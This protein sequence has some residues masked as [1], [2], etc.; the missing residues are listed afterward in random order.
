MILKA[1]KNAYVE[2]NHGVLLQFTGF[3][4]FA[5]LLMIAAVGNGSSLLT[6]LIPLPVICVLAQ[7]WYKDVAEQYRRLKQDTKKGAEAP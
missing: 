1:I 2:D 7:A 3:T 5:V 6:L 4:F